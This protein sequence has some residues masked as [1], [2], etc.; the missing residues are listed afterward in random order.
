M[1]LVL[2]PW[3]VGQLLVM[4]QATRSQRNIMGTVSVLAA[5]HQCFELH[6]AL[7][8]KPTRVHH[9]GFSPLMVYT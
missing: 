8:T 3:A 2:W 7:R 4:A 1:Q 6:E 9:Q 5:P